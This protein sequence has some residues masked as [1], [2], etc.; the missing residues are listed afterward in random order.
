MIRQH[1]PWKPAPA[2]VVEF[3]DRGTPRSA[4]FRDIYYSDEHGLDESQHVF[5]DGSGLPRR[6]QRH[7]LPTFCIGETG[8]GSGLNFLLSWRAWKAARTPKPR[9]HYV[10][11]ERYPL[12]HK[13]IRQTLSNWPQLSPLSEQLLQ[14][15]PGLLPG[16]HRLIFESGR[17]VLDLWWHDADAA[18]R[19]LSTWR[20]PFVDAW[21]LDGF[22]PSRNAQ[23]W[24]PSVLN[25]VAAISREG[26]TLSTFTVAGTVRRTLEEAGFRVEKV[27]GF[28]RKRECLRGTFVETQR[29]EACV[30][31]GWD[32][33]AYQEHL[34]TEVIIIG[35]G[36]AGC[37]TAAALNR[38]GV[39]VI[40]L[41]SDTLAGAGSGNNQGILYHR[42]HREHSPLADFGTQ[43]YQHA[44][45]LYRHLFAAGGL[46]DGV[47]GA[48]C[49][50]FHQQPDRPGLAGVADQLADVSE[51][52]QYVSAS[53]ANDLLGVE[54]SSDGIW[55]PQSGWL[56]PAAVCNALIDSPLS[57]L[58]SGCGHVS[59]NPLPSGWRASARNGQHWDASCVVVAT[60]AQTLNLAQTS[61]LPL[62]AIR[63]QTTDLPYTALPTGLRA[64][65]CHEGYI[66]PARE[67]IYSIGATFDLGDM[68]LA[69]R[70]DDSQRN[71]QLLAKALPA[72]TQSLKRLANTNLEARVGFRCASPDYL[73]LA[74]RVPD[75]GPFAARF[76]DLRRNARLEVE[77]PGCYLPGLF[78]VT[79]LGSR[80]L[81]SAPLLGELIA[82]EVCQELPPLCR[83]LARTLN[84]GRFIIRDLC[85]NRL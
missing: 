6:W 44:V 49:G 16:Q 33:P 8:F 10:S 68:E 12:K 15:Y 67:G 26:A 4:R 22:A 61:W 85:R 48:L 27:R 36:L 59:L 19:H 46:R 71:L 64:A 62:Q 52:A 81:T 50:S 82:S 5:V 77:E 21:Y 11:L 53:A 25:N 75:R 17:I 38:R 47:D 28:G 70:K 3:T 40:L 66:A 30:R 51:Y 63:G 80:G 2:G 13:D 34:P 58:N 73:P 57:T 20:P 56:H 60:G 24:Q 37:M 41:E 74:G 72:W 35:A 18:L 1:I 76:G 43:S 78:V 54:Q 32:S 69:A 9:L 7:D 79:G 65:F 83:D 42:I 84:P 29:R 31:T 39:R 23:M 14:Q 45:T 55:F